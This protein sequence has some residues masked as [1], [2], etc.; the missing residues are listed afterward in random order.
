ML[1]RRY[2]RGTLRTGQRGVVLFIALIVLV[3]M[4]LAAIA[5]MRSVDTTN[6]IAGNLA[7]QQAAAHSGDAAV[8]SAISWLEG[9]NKGSALNG[10][11]SSHGY[12]PD[13]NKPS[14][15]PS[16]GQTW[17]AFWNANAANSYFV[18]QDAA[19][20]KSWYI[21]DRLCNGVGASNLS[22]CASSPLIGGDSGNDTK[23]NNPTPD[24]ASLV[25]YRITVRVEGKARNTV[26][27]LQAMVAL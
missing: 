3:A 2:I 13:G 10:P 8:E 11:D 12:T 14:R 6:I 24:A 26:S 27:Y 1:S 22:A 18:G 17:D 9:C 19:L 7:F 4:T 5:L 21:I 20:N 16:A 25:F 23:S 15:N